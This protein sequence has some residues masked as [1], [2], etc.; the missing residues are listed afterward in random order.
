MLATLG[1]KCELATD[2]DR[3]RVLV[4]RISS[5]EIVVA[6]SV[7]VKGVVNKAAFV[8]MRR[9]ISEIQKL[10]PKIRKESLAMEKYGVDEDGNAKS[11]GKT[12]ESSKKCPKC[13]SDLYKHGDVFL[14]PKCGSEPFEA[15]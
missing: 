6:D 5:E 3:L 4:E 12:A 11:D 14:C 9:S 10:C 13:G 8:R 15:E 2:L 1:D 7:K